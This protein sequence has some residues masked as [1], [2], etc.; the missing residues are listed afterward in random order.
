MSRGTP[1]KC[2]RVPDDV[3][4]RF[5]ELAE[6]NGTTRTALLREW[7]TKYVERQKPD[8]RRPG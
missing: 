4:A 6:A 2:I 1:L 8:T 7:I 5:G 3:W